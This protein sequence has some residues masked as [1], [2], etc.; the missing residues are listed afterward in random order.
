MEKLGLKKITFVDD[1]KG[2]DWTR[3]V[4][5]IF[6]L[7]WNALKAFQLIQAWSSEQDFLA[8]NTPNVELLAWGGD[9]CR[10]QRGRRQQHRAFVMESSS[11]GE[12][13]L[14]KSVLCHLRGDHDSLIQL[15]ARA[16][17]TATPLCAH[18]HADTARFQHL[19]GSH[20]IQSWKGPSRFLYPVINQSHASTMP[21]PQLCELEAQKPREF[22][23]DSKFINP[24]EPTNQDAR[25]GSR[26][27]LV[28]LYT[29]IQR[30]HT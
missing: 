4:Y 17:S 18:R 30:A 16:L 23:D 26:G 13:E 8:Q 27:S 22:G 20:C 21:V 14:P 28:S 1:Y 9:S 25:D 2:D 11:T 19:T 15:R 3:G 6:W 10:R 7:S 5:H 12:A 29:N 24:R